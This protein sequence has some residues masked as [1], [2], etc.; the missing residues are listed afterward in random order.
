MENTQLEDLEI[1]SLLVVM[2]AAHDFADVLAETPQFK[3]FEQA[4]Y[5]L[6]GE[7]EAQRAV[8]AYQK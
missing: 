6:L 8:R 7:Q 1:A 2:Q 5:A 3:A 4:A